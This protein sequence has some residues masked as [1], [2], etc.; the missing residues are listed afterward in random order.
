M[1]EAA[2]EAQRPRCV[3]HSYRTLTDSAFPSNH[4]RQ[5]KTNYSLERIIN[6]IRRRTRAVGVFP[7]KRA[8]LMLSRHDATHRPVSNGA[9]GVMSRWK[10][11]QLL[12]ERQPLEIRSGHPQQKNKSVKGS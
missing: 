4:W 7:D 8:A 3:V 10:H 11:S 1:V 2:T 5:A 12:P 9:R 6:E